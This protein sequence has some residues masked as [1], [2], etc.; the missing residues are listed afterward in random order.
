MNKYFPTWKEADNLI[1]FVA[2][3]LEFNIV[4]GPTY[5]S[6]KIGLLTEEQEM[7]LRRVLI[8][9]EYFNEFNILYE[10]FIN[11]I[12]IES[13]IAKE[14][15]DDL[16]FQPNTEENRYKME[17]YVRQKFKE[18][19]N[20]EGESLRTKFIKH[21]GS[22]FSFPED[23]TEREELNKLLSDVN[24]KIETYVDNR[25]YIKNKL[26]EGLGIPRNFLNDD[27]INVLAGSIVIS[28]RYI[29]LLNQEKDHD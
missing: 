17:C 5:S 29:K 16:L 25:V 4:M 3:N 26:L 7:L 18:L 19:E 13:G 28:N 6:V 14:I 10:Q 2:E 21:M 22:T 20:S 27:D 15:Y 12:L 23:N 8:P 9:H 11:N 24:S 1:L